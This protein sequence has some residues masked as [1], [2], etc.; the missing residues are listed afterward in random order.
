MVRNNK[1]NKEGEAIM[2]WDELKRTNPDTLNYESPT[3]EEEK[4]A[5]SEQQ[6]MEMFARI[7]GRTMGVKLDTDMEEK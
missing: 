5:K 1:Y 4:Q 3:E 7:G 6:V 2:K